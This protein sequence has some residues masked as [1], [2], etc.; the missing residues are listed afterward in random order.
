MRISGIY[1]VKMSMKYSL[2]FLKVF[3]LI[4]KDDLDLV[5]IKMVMNS[6]N[7]KNIFFEISEFQLIEKLHFPKN[8]AI[9]FGEWH[10]ENVLIFPGNVNQFREFTK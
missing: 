4:C 6:D 10:L 1:F 3:R 5:I 7:F 9:I 2:I 8:I